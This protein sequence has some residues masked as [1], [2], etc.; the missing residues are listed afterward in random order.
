M[1]RLPKKALLFPSIVLLLPMKAL[2]RKRI[3]LL[4]PTRVELFPTKAELFPTIV[5]LFLKI[6]LF[7]E[8]IV[9]FRLK[10]RFYIIKQPKLRRKNLEMCKH[11][12]QAKYLSHLS[13]DARLC[14]STKLSFCSI[15][16]GGNAYL[17]SVNDL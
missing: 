17:K 9:E 10:M 2:W 1:L 7:S 16:D 13:R 11:N 12:S 6:V 5:L 8:G 3:A 14:V 4:F 15:S